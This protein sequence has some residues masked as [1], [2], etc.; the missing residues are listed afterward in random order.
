MFNRLFANEAGKKRGWEE[1]NKEYKEYNKR[2]AHGIREQVRVLMQ[3]SS[4]EEQIQ[5]LEKALSYDE[6]NFFS[7]YIIGQTLS[8]QAYSAMKNQE[9]Y[10]NQEKIASIY[11]KALQYWKNL[12]NYTRNIRIATTKLHK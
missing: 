3:N 7:W 9:Q 5:Y 11:G 4:Y 12:S 1:K 6:E 10:R 8:K 2:M